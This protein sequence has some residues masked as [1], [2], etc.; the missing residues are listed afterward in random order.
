MVRPCYRNQRRQFRATRGDFCALELSETPRKRTLSATEVD[1]RNDDFG[2]NEPR[3]RQA[4]VTAAQAGR[5]P[6]KAGQT[7][8]LRLLRDEDLETVS[9]GL[10]V[11][12]ATLSG[13]RDAFLAGGE[14][15]LT[16]RPNAGEALESGCW[17][18]RSWR[19]KVAVLWPGGGPAQGQTEVEAMSR[20]ASPSSGKPYGVARVC[21]LWRDT[22]DPLSPAYPA[23]G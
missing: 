18:P 7:E 23:A 13:W 5:G 17:K 6:A 22:G 14:A 16:T 1:D 2:C 12:A 4:H 11:T 9:R 10:G 3:P 15:S 8:V 20:A 19:W 21:R